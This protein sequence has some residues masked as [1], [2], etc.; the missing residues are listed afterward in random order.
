M[1]VQELR[2]YLEDIDG[3]T[4][5]IFRNTDHTDWDEIKEMGESDITIENDV[6]DGNGDV[7]VE[8]GVIV[9]DTSVV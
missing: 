8:G 3:N 6:S 5:I 2:K 7:L 4:P 9:F 1:T